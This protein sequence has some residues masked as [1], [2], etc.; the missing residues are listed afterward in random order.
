MDVP[1]LRNGHHLTAVVFVTAI[2]VLAVQLLTPA[3]IVVSVGENG[4]Q[5]ARVGQ[6]F[7]HNDVA[8]LVVASLLCGASGTYLLLHDHVQRLVT[9]ASSASTETPPQVEPNGTVETRD[10]GGEANADHEAHVREQWQETATRLTNN[11][12]TLYTRLIEADGE[13]PQRT[14]VEETDLSKATVSR[15]LDKLEH[16]GLLE[17]KRNGMG[18]VIRLPEAREMR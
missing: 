12:E 15:T 3:P 14:L 18:N 5:T 1:A 16:R 13:L 10:G 11:E 8:V 17:R 6:Y 2:L 4:T 7:T 9:D